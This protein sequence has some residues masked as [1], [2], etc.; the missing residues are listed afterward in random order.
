MC[1]NRKIIF[2]TSRLHSLGSTF[3][4]YDFLVCPYQT[5]LVFPDQFLKGSGSGFPAR[6]RWTQGMHGSECIWGWSWIAGDVDSIPLQCLGYVDA[7]RPKIS[8]FYEILDKKYG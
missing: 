4:A 6:L 8:R 7:K 1:G 5:R 2:Q 3:G